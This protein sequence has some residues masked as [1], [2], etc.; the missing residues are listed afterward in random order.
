MRPRSPT[1]Q[2]KQ[3]W[4]LKLSRDIV[5]FVAGLAGVLHETVFQNGERP[6]LLLLYAAMMGLPLY[7]RKNGL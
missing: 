2:P 3:K 6:T 5:L 4:R 7:L 1:P